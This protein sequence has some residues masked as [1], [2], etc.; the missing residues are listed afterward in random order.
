MTQV[1]KLDRAGTESLHFG[2]VSMPKAVGHLLARAHLE[3][4]P[5]LL[6][7]PSAFPALATIQGYLFTTQLL[8]LY[9]A[10]KPMGVVEFAIMLIPSSRV[11]SQAGPMTSCVQQKVLG[12]CIVPFHW[13]LPL[14]LS[15]WH[16]GFLG[17]P[18]SLPRFLHPVYIRFEGCR[19]AS[20]DSH[21]S[22]A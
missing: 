6:S 21:I 7:S 13:S 19:L 18:L 15:P 16:L 4:R 5:M 1:G 22:L 3:R 14:P 10:A 11:L 12:M 2:A 8:E 9:F 20:A 17:L